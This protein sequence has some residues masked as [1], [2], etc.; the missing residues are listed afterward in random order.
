MDMFLKEKESQRS[1]QLLNARQSH[2]LVIDVQE[3]F[4][5]AIVRLPEIAARVAILAKA[6]KMLEIP[7]L[8]SEQNPKALGPTL[9]LISEVLGPSQIYHGKMAFSLFDIDACA[10]QLRESRRR[11]IVVCGIETHVCVLQ[12]VADLLENLG[13][14]VCVVKDAVASRRD[15]DRD[16]AFERLA[17]MG[18][19]L[20]TT[21][22]V[23][24]EWLRQAGS[25]EFKALQAL[26]K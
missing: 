11:Q 2:L 1:P 18:A 26:L 6:A 23:V 7:I 16:A 3:K 15:S 13:A 19:Q 22:M 20:V 4:A 24:F 12:T 5:S 10:E 17:Q 8:A 14:Q 9:P 21:E 25:P